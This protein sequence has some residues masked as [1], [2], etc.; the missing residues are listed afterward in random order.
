MAAVGLM[1]DMRILDHKEE[2][3]SYYLSVLAELVFAF[4]EKLAN[5]N[6]NSYN[7]FTL[8]VGMNIGP[9][10]AGVIG[11]RKPQYDIWGNTVN[12]AS[13][14]DSTGLPNHTQVRHSY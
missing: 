2:S 8:R 14:M 13:R 10:V 3:A 5:I 4:R 11:A 9:V 6:E 1:P 7:N 12:V